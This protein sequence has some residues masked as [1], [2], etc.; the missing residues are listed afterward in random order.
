MLKMHQ[1][2]QLAKGLHIFCGL[3]VKQRIS[4]IVFRV[5]FDVTE[6]RFKDDLSGLHTIRGCLERKYFELKQASKVYFNFP[7]RILRSGP[8]IVNAARHEAKR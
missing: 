6:H 7:K 2:S 5:V 4:R 3:Q 8:P 1:K